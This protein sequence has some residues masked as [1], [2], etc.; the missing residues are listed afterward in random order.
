MNSEVAS[1]KTSAEKN[2]WIAKARFRGL[3]QEMREA[4]L[5]RRK[6]ALLGRANLPGLVL[7]CIEAKFC[8]KICV[9]KLSPRSTQCTPLH[10]S[11]IS[12]FCQNFAK[13]FAEFCKSRQLAKNSKK[14]QFFEK[15]LS[16]FLGK[17]V[18]SEQCKGVHCVDLDESFQTHI[19]L[20]NLA[21]IQPRTSPLKFVGSRDS[22][23]SRFK[24]VLSARRIRSTQR[25]WEP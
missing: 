18:I 21:S 11:A 12:I 25:Q 2:S 16:N 17:H 20:Q 19:Y 23:A 9:W 15:I 4:S 8:K 1:S 13:S 10:S 7:G 22:W 5:G 24:K 6:A 14:S 3:R